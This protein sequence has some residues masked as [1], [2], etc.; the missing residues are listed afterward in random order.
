MKEREIQRVIDSCGVSKSFA[1]T[2]LLSHHWNSEHIIDC[3]WRGATDAL[4]Q[5]NRDILVSKAGLPKAGPLHFDDEISS[6]SEGI[7]EICHGCPDKLLQKQAVKEGIRTTGSQPLKKRRKKVQPTKG[8]KAI[9][10]QLKELMK[11]FEVN[12]PNEQDI[13]IFEI[14]VKCKGMWDGIVS[15]FSIT[16]PVSE[17][18]FAQPK[19]V[20]CIDDSKK[21]FHP[22]ISPDDGTVCLSMLNSDWSPM[23][24]LLHLCE[25]I[26]ELF[27]VPNWGHSLNDAC[28]EMFNNRQVDFFKH[29]KKLGAKNPAKG[30]AKAKKRL[31][32][33]NGNASNNNDRARSEKTYAQLKK[34]PC[35]ELTAALS[36]KHY[37]CKSCWQNHLGS[38]FQN[39]PH[40]VFT[41]CPSPQCKKIITKDL[42]KAVSTPP[43]LKSFQ[44]FY[45]QS[46]VNENKCFNYCP[47][48]CGQVFHYP[49]I[50][51]VTRKI[52]CPCG[53]IFCWGCLKED[54]N[55]LSCENA[56]AWSVQERKLFK[57]KT[58]AD[59]W[60]DQNVK[61][62]P[63]CKKRI[64]KD[65]GCMHVTCYKEK[66][67]C[68]YQ[69]CWLCKGKWSEHGN[70]T[71]GFYACTKY[72][73]LGK[74]GKL[75]GE[76]AVAF[77]AKTFEESKKEA[78][79]KYEFHV[80]RFNF[81][82]SSVGHANDRMKIFSDW[83]KDLTSNTAYAQSESLIDATKTL[84]EVRNALKW[85]Y[86]AKYY[87]Q[88]ESQYASLLE[89]NHYNL[90]AWTDALQASLEKF[91][92]FDALGVS[93]DEETTRL[94]SNIRTRKAQVK[95]YLEDI[96]E[97]DELQMYF[98]D[99]FESPYS[100]KIKE[101]LK[102]YKNVRNNEGATSTS[103]SISSSSSSSS[104]NRR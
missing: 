2:L 71:G 49:K 51:S 11:K 53:H 15:R 87:V 20:V 36:C 86:V 14:T 6:I 13:S 65:G 21:V 69:F 35:T 8:V 57:G 80:E 102:A 9:N 73:E 95:K 91:K 92:D 33:I 19:S 100:F 62:C 7:C 45:L 40:S 54:H 90:E 64:W 101:G 85:I 88:K 27:I 37:Y 76:S 82:E 34:L 17:Y 96:C 30:L 103:S 44:K 98:T 79:K 24:T 10:R 1:A 74:S 3:W 43:S 68:G 23:N 38:K 39:G 18:P 94:V 47:K 67:G 4:I 63:K 50:N 32:D 42:V 26:S 78:L 93:T 97:A 5:E 41:C 29:L 72:E 89:C 22:N 56:E 60:T 83:Q 58:R 52:D 84:K 99:K 59:L 16:L 55:P 81:Q 70:G 48:G 46:Y 75:T 28:G 104:S 31:S 77:A 25:A 12:L 61:S 66:G